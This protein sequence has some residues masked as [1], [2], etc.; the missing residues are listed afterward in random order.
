MQIQELE[1]QTGLDRA[2]IRFYEKEGLIQPLRLQNG[3]RDYSNKNLSD[4]LKIKL[5]RQIGLPVDTIRQ[6]MEGREELQSVLDN[7]LSVIQNRKDFLTNAEEVCRQMKS[8]RVS[9]DTV[10]PV[11][12]LNALEETAQPHSARVNL[13]SFPYKEIH[14][15]RRFVARQA[16]EFLL[17]VVLLLIVVVVLRIRPYS[18]IIQNIINLVAIFLV[19]PINALFLRIFGTTPGKW[20]MGI[21]LEATDGT[22]MRFMTALEREWQVLR[23]GC[24]FYLPIYSLYRMYKSYKVHKEGQELDWDYDHDAELHYTDYTGRRATAVGIAAVIIVAAFFWGISQSMLP[25]YRGSDISVSEF[26]SNYNAF[27]TQNGLILRLSPEGEWVFDDFQGENVVIGEETTSKS[28]KFDKNG[29]RISK[30]TQNYAVSDASSLIIPIIPSEMELCV[31]TAIASQKGTGLA[32]INSAMAEFSNFYS[33]SFQPVNENEE[34]CLITGDW[35]YKNITVR[36]NAALTGQCESTGSY[37][38][39][40]DHSS[41]NLTIIIEVS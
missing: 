34:Q 6:L 20:A 29:E 9:F 12:Y 35:T 23:Y 24:G 18:E 19:V 21:R 41:F 33:K 32:E 38:I 1:R 14:P 2:T 36:W 26:V 30:I 7:Q 22:K 40:E 28:S 10:E 37:I 5:L 17:R 11:K 4:L 15:V 16:D 25:A 8:D 39:P 27:A 31:Y 13:Q 3:Y